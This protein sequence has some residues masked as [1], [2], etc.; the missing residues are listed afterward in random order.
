MKRF[1]M[2]L[3]V[4]TLTCLPALAETISFD[5]EVTAAYTRE[6]YAASTAIVE[7]VPV[8]VGQTVAA[9]ETV[10]LLRTNK[11]YAEEAGKVAAVF[12]TVGDLTD[13]VAQ[14]YGAVLYL[15]GKTV[16]RVSASTQYAYDSIATKQAH[17]GERVSLRSRTNNMRVGKGTVVA[18]NGAEY[19]V[20]VTSGGFEENEM[21]TV[22]RGEGYEDNMRLGRGVVSLVAPTAVNGTGRIVSLA[23]QA[24]DNV[25]RG[26][27]LMET[28]D[29][30]GTEKTLTADLAGVVAQLNIAQGATIA[31]NAVAVVLWPLDAMQIE[32]PVN[33]ND[34]AFISEGDKV[35]LSFDWNA[36]SDEKLTGVVR[37]ISSI[38]Q[39]EDDNTIY[40]A[41][42]D[43]EP[44]ASVRYGMSVTVQTVEPE[45]APEA[46]TTEDA[47]EA[48][49]AEDTEEN[50]E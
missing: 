18:V 10:A 33:E 40:M 37:S 11:V 38:A 5:G 6:I 16:Y 13:V 8:T 30:T 9:G 12:G 24:G 20:H 41:K 47:P 26:A 19:S 28:L 1:L 4:L 23:V 36:D 15:E 35:S 21:V 43:F 49:T 42:V 34:L 46:S 31:E 14:R 17:V 48:P 3:L 22:Y 29:G 2:L 32:F 7:S 45:D 44:T 27:L 25:E 50:E 39:M